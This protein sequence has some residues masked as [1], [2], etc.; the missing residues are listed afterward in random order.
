M[1]V[2]D[3]RLARIESEDLAGLGRAD[4]DDV[5]EYVH[6]PT[7]RLPG[8]RPLYT[9]TCGSAGTSTTSTSPRTG[10]TGTGG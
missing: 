7:A 5:I 6:V 4:I 8:Y 2:S 9:G 3:T 10:R 1:T